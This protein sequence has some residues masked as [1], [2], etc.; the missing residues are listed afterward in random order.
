M[1]LVDWSGA[2]RAPRAWSLAFLLWS[3]GLGGDLARVDRVID[4][5]RRR[6]RTAPEELDR[7]PRRVQLISSRPRASIGASV[8]AA[9]SRPGSGSGWRRLRLASTDIAAPSL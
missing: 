1:V 7:R 5:Y 2:G 9:N 6:V 3:V 4:G 8:W